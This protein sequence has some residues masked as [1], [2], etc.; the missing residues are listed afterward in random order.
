MGRKRPHPG[1]GSLSTSGTGGGGAISPQEVC[2]GESTLL[3]GKKS[4]RRTC[5]SAAPPR[6][7]S[8]EFLAPD[9][10]RVR[11]LLTLLLEDYDV[12][13]VSQAYIAGLKVTSVI[14]PKLG[15]IKA[16]KLTPLR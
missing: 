14:G 5:I 13:G 2:D 11:D 7:A 8:G 4:R 15:N 6:K 3:P 12:R 16:A 1:R 10:V 9:R